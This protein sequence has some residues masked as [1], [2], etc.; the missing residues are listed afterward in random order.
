MFISIMVM[1]PEDTYV[2]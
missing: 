1:R 2:N